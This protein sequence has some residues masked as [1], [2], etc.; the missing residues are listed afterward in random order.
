M[1]NINFEE[2]YKEFNINNDPNRVLRFNPRDINIIDRIEDAQAQL[3]AEIKELEK[4]DIS[5]TEMVKQANILLKNLTDGIFY[6]GSYEIVFNGQNPLT[7]I[8]GKTIYERFFESIVNV[9]RPFVN[10]EKVAREKRMSKYKEIY[11]RVPSE[12]IK[13]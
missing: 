11:D 10:K 7:L 2:G 4:K 5:D 8:N 13:G 9:M 3:K 6:E 1:N 12:N